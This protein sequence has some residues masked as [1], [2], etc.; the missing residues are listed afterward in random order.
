MKSVSIPHRYAEN[1]NL[2]GG[3]TTPCRVS[4]PHRYAENPCLGNFPNIMDTQFQFLIGT[5]RTDH[6]CCV[7]HI[8][9]KFQFLI[10]TL[11][12]PTLFWVPWVSITGFNSS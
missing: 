1:G 8:G 9:D 2:S 10:G 12:T 5:L 7:G 3:F 11:R 4:I 6:R